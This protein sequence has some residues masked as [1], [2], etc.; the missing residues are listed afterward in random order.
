MARKYLG[1]AIRAEEKES[2]IFFKR[3]EQKEVFCKLKVGADSF[4][5][6]QDVVC[7]NMSLHKMI[8]A[9]IFPFTE[10]DMK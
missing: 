10:E 9:F 7:D 8:V 3:K 1:F 5:E 6:A 2:G 4:A